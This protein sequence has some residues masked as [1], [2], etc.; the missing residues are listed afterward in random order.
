M[1]WGDGISLLVSVVGLTI[2]GLSY[3]RSKDAIDES[4]LAPTRAVQQQRVEGLRESMDRMLERLEQVN[5]DIPLAPS[6]E[7]AAELIGAHADWLFNET[8]RLRKTVLSDQKVNDLL[9]DL[10]DRTVGEHGSLIDDLRYFARTVSDIS[11]ARGD[12]RDGLIANWGSSK[13][14][15]LDRNR[16]AIVAAT[17]VKERAEELE[18]WGLGPI[19]RPSERAGRFDRVLRRGRDGTAERI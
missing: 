17:A 19:E 4:R 12:R 13:R 3:K 7:D 11:T 10:R 18:R 16:E 2:A 15:L 14:P 9:R 6:D 1:D 5:A 8:N